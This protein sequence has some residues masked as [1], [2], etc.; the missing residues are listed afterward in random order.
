MTI[1][2]HACAGKLA[3]SAGVIDS[4]LS[5]WLDEW[6]RLST[7]YPRIDC[8]EILPTGRGF[9][10][11][12]FQLSHMAHFSSVGN[13]QMRCVPPEWIWQDDILKQR[14]L[15]GTSA[16]WQSP[17]SPKRFR[18]HPPSRSSSRISAQE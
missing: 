8:R 10:N 12:Q 1:H 7:P 13:F 9:P 3:G 18:H 11:L 5:G 2:S 4:D 14:S 17:I 16:A 15:A 6:F